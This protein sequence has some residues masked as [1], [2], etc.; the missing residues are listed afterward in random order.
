MHSDYATPA[1]TA[2]LILTPMGGPRGYPACRSRL[3][4]VLAGESACPTTNSKARGGVP[5]GCA[6]SHY[7]VEG[8]DHDGSDGG[9]CERGGALECR[10]AARRRGGWGLLLFGADDGR[11]QIGRASCMENG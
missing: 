9:F 11:V 10:G 2:I 6:I 7:G 1:K 3:K 8:R 4:K 5:R